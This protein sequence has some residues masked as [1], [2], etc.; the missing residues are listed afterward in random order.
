MTFVLPTLLTLEESCIV[1]DIKLENFR[2]TSGYRES[3]GHKILVFN[4]LNSEYKTHRYNP[5]DYVSA[6]IK[7]KIN[8]LYK[9]A[10]LLIGENAASK[11]LFVGL[12]LYSSAINAKQTIGEIARMVNDDL[13]QELSRGLKTLDSSKRADCIKM[14]NGFLSQSSNSKR[15]AIDHLKTA[16]YLWLNPFIDYATSASDFDIASF[17]NNKTTLYVG[18]QP[19]D[20]ERLKPLMRL[21]YNHALAELVKSAESCVTEEENGGVTVMLDEFCTIGKLEKYTFS[22]LRGYKVRLCLI[23]SDIHQIE[24]L[25]GTKETFDIVSNCHF[26][27]F[28]APHDRETAQYISSLC[29]DHTEPREL[30]SWQQIMAL[31]QDEQIVLADQQPLI[32][33][34]KT[35]YYDNKELEARI[36]APVNN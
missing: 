6:D 12:A 35:K 19:T 36:I 13:E 11:I 2:C 3:I 27:V 8:D 33:S 24:G 17:K 9:I 4:P 20:I 18:L 28:F 30:L 32:I 23:A 21:F 5:L 25:Y 31:P 26:K 34:K 1:H 7:K 22:Y 10:D 29:I 15:K 16:L 14:L